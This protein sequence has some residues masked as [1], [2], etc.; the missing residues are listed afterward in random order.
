M[1]STGITYHRNVH[2]LAE[3]MNRTGITERASFYQSYHLIVKDNNFFRS[4]HSHHLYQK[5]YY[6]DDNDIENG[7]DNDSDNGVSEV[8]IER[9]VHRDQY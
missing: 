8:N 9:K 7:H 2:L 1:G 3:R 4:P 5:I 6:I